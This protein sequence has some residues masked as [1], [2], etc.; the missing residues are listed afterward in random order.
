MI[1]TSLP[2]IVLKGIVLLPHCELR[3]EFKDD[4]EKT[5]LKNAEEYSD[6]H[7]VVVTEIDKLEQN[8]DVKKLPKVV[9][10]IIAAI[11]AFVGASII[12][13]LLINVLGV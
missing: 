1:K 3:V 8:V 11:I 6:N 4:L 2:V 9:Q 7:I 10:M 12:K 5:I 13:L